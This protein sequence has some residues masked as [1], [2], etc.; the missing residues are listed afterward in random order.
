MHIEW[1]RRINRW[2][3]IR[4][5]LHTDNGSKHLG[6]QCII[7][8]V[9]L[10]DQNNHLCWRLA[11]SPSE[12]TFGA[13]TIAAKACLHLQSSIWLRKGFL[14]FDSFSYFYSVFCA[15]FFVVCCVFFVPWDF[16]PCACWVLSYLL[17]CLSLWLFLLFGI[18]VCF[19]LF[20]VFCHCSFAEVS[21]C[22]FFGLLLFHGVVIFLCI[23]L[24]L[25]CLS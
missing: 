19:S 12:D 17:C 24:H 13:C 5:L 16:A 25:F 3:E 1:V 2:K 18:C 4:F 7:T 11:A 8:N 10:L 15:C 23:F 22:V 6:F 9:S 20:V 14:S 21:V